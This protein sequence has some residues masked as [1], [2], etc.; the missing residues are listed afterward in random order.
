MRSE[1]EVAHFVGDHGRDQVADSGPSRLG[2]FLDSVKKD[3]A[4][5]SVPILPEKGDPKSR[6][7]RCLA[8]PNDI[9]EKF[10]LARNA[11]AWVFSS[12]SRRALKPM[13]LYSGKR[14]DPAGL[15]LRLP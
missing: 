14:E 5:L 2:C 1:E 7:Q 6:I 10:V 12:Q 3:V 9:C 15:R 11:P 13:N 8:R 4:I